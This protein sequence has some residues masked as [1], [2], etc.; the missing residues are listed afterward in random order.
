MAKRA[1]GD[2]EGALADYDAA[3][4]L[5]SGFAAAWANRGSIKLMLGDYEGARADCR[6]PKVLKGR[7]MLTGVPKERWKE[8][9]IW[10]APILV[11]E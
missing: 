4:R 9:A 1:L 7:M 10:S 5:D 11:A 3:I 8:R 6:G 2:P